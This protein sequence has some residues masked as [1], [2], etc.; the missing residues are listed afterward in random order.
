MNYYEMADFELA[1]VM[2]NYIFRVTHL[3]NIISDYLNGNDN[4]STLQIRK[5]YEELKV[6]LRE[7]AHYLGLRKNYHGSVLYMGGFA[8][9]I[10]EAAAYGFGVPIHGVVNQLMYNSVAEAHYRLTKYYSLEEW[11]ELL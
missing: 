4:I 6:E 2:V 11:G 1:S 9:S 7:E 10:K 5:E 8:P 3:Q